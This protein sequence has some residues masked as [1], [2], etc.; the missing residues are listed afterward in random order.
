[1]APDLIFVLGLVVATVVLFVTETFRVDVVALLALGLLLIGGILPPEDALAGFSNEAVV[2][3]GAM[4]VL[5]EGLF[6]SGTLNALGQQ[7]ERLAERD[8]RVAVLA[9]M[10]AAGV[11]SAFINNTAVVAVLMPMLLTTAR[12]MHVSASKTLMPLSFASMFGGVCTLIGTSTNLLVS[13]IAND[14]GFE[15]FGMF[16]LTALGVVFFAAGTLYMLTVGM[17]LTP[18]RRGTER[19]TEGWRLGQYITELVLLPGS[20]SV[21]M[22]VGSAPLARDLDVDV[23]QILRS[24]RV[25]PLPP[26]PETVLEA[27]D[28]LLVR[29]D[30]RQLDRL[31]RRE[32][33][34]IE[35]RTK[36]RSEDFESRDL[37]L[38]EVVIAPNSTLE[39]ETLRSSDFRSRFGGT[40][41]ALRHRGALVRDKLADTR[42]RAGDALMVETASS[43]LPQ[44]QASE[45][46]VIVSNLPRAHFR[47]S[48]ALPALTILALVVGTA[49]VGLAPIVVTATAGAVAMLLAGCLTADEAYRAVD[50]K[51]VFLLVGVLSLG[52]A[53]E[54]TGGAELLSRGL[55]VG[56][57][58]LGPVALISAVYLATTL[59]TNAM[60]NNATAVLVAPIAIAVAQDV[61]ADP[62]PFL[63]AVTFAA[64]S[65]FMTPVGYQT[66]TM[67][68][69]PGQYRF[70]DFLRVGAPLNLLFWILATVLIPRLWPL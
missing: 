63:M 21:G 28:V 65:S 64:S 70:A 3:I 39:G 44:F 30:V 50:W 58:N 18:E 33:V 60:S 27:G 2:T 25:R 7:F 1:M 31:L 51:V 40:V 24:G 68:Y 5:S 46:F 19:L 29:C 22:P 12:D 54:R 32:G 48:K 17:R 55:I 26:E 49:A 23:L 47:P 16:E 41:I 43:R 69:G 4:F 42:L 36:W 59:L 53:L 56:V 45:A 61:G 38:V 8:P 9:L 15:P 52:V 34:L 57:G 35:S 37:A 67:I 66:N 10:L 6:R 14:H 62:R 13:A 20:R 11:F